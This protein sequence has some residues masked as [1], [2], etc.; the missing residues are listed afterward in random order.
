MTREEAIET[1]RA[2]YPD[3]CFEQLRE[4]VDKAIKALE[5]DA[6]S[7]I[8]EEDVREWCYKR[9]LT[10]LDNTVYL[11]MRSKW[12]ASKDVQPVRHDP[13]DVCDGLEDED[14]LYIYSEWDGA[15]GFDH[16]RDIHF[17]PKCGRRLPNFEICDKSGKE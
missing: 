5:A 6:Q 7:E 2:N 9:C 12:Y 14:T 1:L 8:T 17:C 4:A 15:I 3:A 10:I 13:C 16:I 11:E